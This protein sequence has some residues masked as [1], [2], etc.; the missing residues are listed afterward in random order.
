MTQQQLT[1]PRPIPACPAGHTARYIHDGRGLTAK[2]G[3]FIECRCCC[4]GKHA[5]FDLAWAHWYKMH[6]FLPTR[7]VVAA[8]IPAPQLQLR[9][10]EK[11]G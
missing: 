2:G 11:V 7:V 9:L 8:S 6:G 10:V 1:P 5:T 3:D 4:T